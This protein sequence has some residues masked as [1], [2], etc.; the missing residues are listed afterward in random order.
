MKGSMLVTALAVGAACAP[1][2]PARNDTIAWPDTTDTE[3]VAATIGG[4]PLVPG[5]RVTM[6]TSPQGVGGYSGCNWYG[7]R[8]DSER[9]LVEMTARGC[10][11]DIQDQER[12]LA[13]LLPQAVRAVRRNDTLV[14]LDRVPSQL[15]AFVRR[16]P[17]PS[18]PSQ[19]VGTGWRLASS[20]SRFVGIDSVWVRFGTDSV[21]GFGGCREFDGTY[22]ARSDR[23]RFTRIAMRALEC[24]SERARVAEEHLTTV[25]SETEHFAIRTDT[26][27]L[28]TFGGDTLR[29]W[30]LK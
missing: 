11:S 4:S 5:T 14:L 16:H 21:S 20:T 3:W 23:L 25:F 1:A 10:R 13:V 26:L 9:T 2:A 17:S 22:S 6:R 19:L 15:I 28:T 24:A 12:R 7:L 30:R 27:L 29:F 18:D 8:N